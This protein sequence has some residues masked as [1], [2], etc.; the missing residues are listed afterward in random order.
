VYQLD[1]HG[2]YLPD[3][4]HI[5]A[6]PGKYRIMPPPDLNE[7]V[8]GRFLLEYDF[9]LL[10][11]RDISTRAASDEGQNEATMQ[12]AIWHHQHP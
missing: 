4:T 9:P 11:V 12:A 7:M 5:Q 6:T 2:D 10:L 1:E 3:G 8:E